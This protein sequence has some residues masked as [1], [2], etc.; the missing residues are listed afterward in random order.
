[1]AK[2]KQANVR[3]GQMVTTFGP[4]VMIDLPDSAVM[5]SSLEH[6]YYDKNEVPP[7]IEEPR[8]LAVVRKYFETTDF[9]P[10]DI[11]KRPPIE[12][13]NEW[14]SKP[15]VTV[16]E[17]PEWFV[18]QKPEFVKGDVKRRR[19]IPRDQLEKGRFKDDAGKRQ[20]V[21]PIR[22]IRGCK[23]G[24]CED[25]DW[26]VFAHDDENT[27]CTHPLYIE[28]RGTTG[29]LADTWIVCGCGADPRSMSQAAKRDKNSLGFCS[30]RRPWLGG[31]SHD[32]CSEPSR[33]LIRSASNA[34]FSQILSVI[35]IPEKAGALVE[36]IGKLWDK[37]LKGIV[38]HGLTLD[39]V[40]S[41]N[42]EIAEALKDYSDDE[43]N[44]GIEAF[45]SD[46]KDEERSPKPA[47]LEVLSNVIEESGTDEPNGDFFAR[48]MPESAWKDGRPWME[49]FSKIVLVHRLREVIAQVGFTRFEPMTPTLSGD[50]DNTIDLNVESAPLSRDAN[51]VPAFENRGEGIFLQFD[52]DYIRE[53]SR[54]VEVLERAKVLAEGFAEKYSSGDNEREFYGVP[55]YMVHSFSHLLINQ[56][57]LECGYPASSLRERIYA[58]D[59]V[60]GILLYT[61][62][63]DAEGTLGGLIQAGRDISNIV[64]RALRSAELCGNDPVCA[65][66]EPNAESQRELLGAA[67]HGCLLVAETSCEHRN[68]FLD[69]NL[70]V[71]TMG[72]S[73]G[74]FFSNYEA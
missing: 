45:Q 36:I 26:R 22:F 1:M 38:E 51:W 14:G 34:Y 24:H 71:K 64:K 19:L 21:V 12:N 53:W 57:S 73:Q 29:A 47:E 9:R 17:F 20:R 33:L 13:D 28:E 50:Y 46:G 31:A 35:S 65:S 15:N 10:P 18:V 32:R 30:G 61:G 5:V 54:R 72:P 37:G 6:W 74:K 62:S 49:P 25:I 58:E 55:F 27:K 67:C 59:G 43:V 11:L 52:S 68:S 63:S 41:M 16:W 40:K 39:V 4:G 56:I 60:Y 70:L 8:L 2:K 42:V 69:R 48:S 23:R 66:Q 7:I 44:A 3:A